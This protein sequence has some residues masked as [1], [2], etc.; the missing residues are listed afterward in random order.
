[1][2]RHRAPRTPN[3][4]PRPARAAALAVLLLAASPVARAALAQ[5]PSTFVGLAVDVA[6]PVGEFREHV[7]LGAGVAFHGVARAPGRAGA[8]AVRAEGGIVRYGSESRSVPLARGYAGHLRTTLTTSNDIAWVGVGPQ[9]I[10]P[11]GPARPYV[12]GAVGAAS[13]VTQSSLADPRGDDV[14]ARY[15]ELE[16]LVLS[17]GGGAGVLVPVKRESDLT[18]LL[19]VGARF[20]H[21][22]RTRYL[23]PGGIEEGYGGETVLHPIESAANLW[24]Y[25]V[26]LSIGM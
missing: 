20:H 18:I 23:R 16:T 12:H 9:L 8:L 3:A 7:R 13:F 14:L 15:T 2:S 4:R 6:R 5:S 22:G 1:M 17:Y 24:T 25:H 11:R 19:D 10:V 26:G 21:N